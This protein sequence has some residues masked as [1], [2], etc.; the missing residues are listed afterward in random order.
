MSWSSL[1]KWSKTRLGSDPNEHIFGGTWERVSMDKTKRK[2]IRQVMCGGGCG[3][4]GC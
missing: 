3:N 1:K 4:A 2:V